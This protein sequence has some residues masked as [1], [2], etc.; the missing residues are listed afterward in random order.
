MRPR[1]WPP[2]PTCSRS[3]A[4]IGFNL[5]ELA[6]VLD[7]PTPPSIHLAFVPERNA[8]QGREALQLR[9]TDLRL[10]EGSDDVPFTA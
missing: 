3:T 4:A 9:V 1:P 7:R 2:A 5:G 8:W 10:C 6:E